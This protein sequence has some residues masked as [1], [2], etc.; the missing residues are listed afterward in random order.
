MHFVVAGTGLT[1][2]CSTLSRQG[3]IPEHYV[4]QKPDARAAVFGKLHVESY[5][6]PVSGSLSCRA[7]MVTSL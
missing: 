3:L 6:Y 1:D 4:T 2:L 7:D 5:T